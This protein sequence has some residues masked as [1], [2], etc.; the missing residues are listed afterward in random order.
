MSGAPYLCARTGSNPSI[1]RAVKKLRF[2]PAG[3]VQR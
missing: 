2:L 1:N 3:Y